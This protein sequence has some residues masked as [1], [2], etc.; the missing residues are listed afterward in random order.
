MNIFLTGAGGFVGGA[1]CYYLS[2]TD[3]VTGLVHDRHPGKRAWD[4]VYGDVTDLRRMQE[5]IVDREIDQVYHFAAKSIVGNCRS[6]PL[7]CFHANVMGTA[8]LLEAV[9]LSGRDCQ[10]M[11]MESDK[12][13]GPGPVPYRE[14][15]PLVASG[16]YE[17]SKACVSHLIRT[18]HANYGMKV[19]GIRSANI[20]GP[21]DRNRSRIIPGTITRLLNNDLPIIHVGSEH[22]KR[23]YIYIADFFEY[24]TSLMHKGPWGESVNVG[25]GEVFSVIDII[26]AI[27]VAM[28]RDVVPHYLPRPQTFLEIPDQELCLD[29]LHELAPEHKCLSFTA[30]LQQTI[31]WYTRQENR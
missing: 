27:C 9:R 31:P 11:C 2:E 20:Y 4:L 18:Y 14:E 16:V 26:G 10:V 5:L 17:A 22:S 3:N 1:F 19:F 8:T 30:G 23:E 25:S 13:Y 7:G 15:Q 28:K 12:A 29:R 24:A 21:G 6:D